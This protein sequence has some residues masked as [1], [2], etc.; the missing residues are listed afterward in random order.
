MLRDRRERTCQ[1]YDQGDWPGV[2]DL[3]W[4][5]QDFSSFTLEVSRPKKPVNPRCM[6]EKVY[7]LGILLLRSQASGVS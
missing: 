4:F 5:A 1:G 3:S 2:T 6:T 7:I